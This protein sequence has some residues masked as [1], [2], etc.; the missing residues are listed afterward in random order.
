[1]TEL[2]GKYWEGVER[3]KAEGIIYQPGNPD[4]PYSHRKGISPCNSRKIPPDVYSLMGLWPS[5]GPRKIL[6]V[7]PGAGAAV[8]Q[9]SHLFPHA[10]I[11]TA[12]GRT[13]INPYLKF[14]RDVFVSDF[15]SSVHCAIMQKLSEILDAAPEIDSLVQK[16]VF[17]FGDEVR[18]TMEFLLE[19]QEQY[20]I[21]IFDEVADPY[22]H[23]QHVSSWYPHGSPPLEEGTYD[24]IY[25]RMGVH[26]HVGSNELFRATYRLLSPQGMMLMNS[27]GD[28]PDGEKPPLELTMGDNM[29]TV[30]AQN[31]LYIPLKSNSGGI[32][33]YFRMSLVA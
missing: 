14:S 3:A 28:F 18:S 5:P 23:L 2:I 15:T 21:H 30:N 9:L 29:C 1:M 8:S 6:E 16:L 33:E 17:E 24:L 19:L 20:R 13:A 7:G 25:E 27:S 31:P 4:D 10:V 26:H 22:I 11:H 12:G 32:R